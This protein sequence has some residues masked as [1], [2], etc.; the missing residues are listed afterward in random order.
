[1][2]KIEAPHLMAAIIS[3]VVIAMFVLWRV[4]TMT[5][6]VIPSII[7]GSGALGMKLLE[8]HGDTK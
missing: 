2:S 7:T 6:A 4:P 8:N 3:L 5:E 1:M